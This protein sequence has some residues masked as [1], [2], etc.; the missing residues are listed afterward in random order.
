MQT[1]I[2]TRKEVK[3]SA[4]GDECRRWIDSRVLSACMSNKSSLQDCRAEKHLKY[5]MKKYIA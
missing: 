1:F 3:K 5:V 4:D 2:S